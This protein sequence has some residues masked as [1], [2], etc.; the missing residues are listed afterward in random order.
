MQIFFTTFDVD[1]LNNSA[2]MNLIQFLTMKLY[3]GPVFIDGIVN[4]TE[5]VVHSKTN[6]MKVVQNQLFFRKPTDIAR[7]S[8]DLS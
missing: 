3:Q 8:C 1:Q 2:S 6:F 7:L 4:S 5:V